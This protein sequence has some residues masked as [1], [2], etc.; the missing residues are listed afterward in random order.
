M[1]TVVALI[2]DVLLIAA[3][4]EQVDTDALYYHIALPLEFWRSGSWL[5][6]SFVQMVLDQ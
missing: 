5:V 2:R 3:T 6:G 1:W 4:A